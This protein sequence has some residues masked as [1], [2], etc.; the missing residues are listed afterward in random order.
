VRLNTLVIVILAAVVVPVVMAVL[1]ALGKVD[2][3]TPAAAADD[4]DPY[5]A[6]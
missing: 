6:L 4:S 2:Q 1:I 5:T 3:K